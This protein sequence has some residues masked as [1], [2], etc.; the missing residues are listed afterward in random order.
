MVQDCEV[1]FKEDDTVK[2]DLGAH[3]DGYIAV[4]AHTIHLGEISGRLAECM[5][6]TLVIIGLFSFLY[7]VLFLSL[8]LSLSL[9]PSLRFLL[10]CEQQE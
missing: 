2:I 9:S 1:T 8:S 5:M 3:I 10:F 7:F 4:A 6:V